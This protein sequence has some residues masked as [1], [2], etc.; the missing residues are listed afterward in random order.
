M[1]YMISKINIKFVLSV[2]FFFALTATAT[3]TFALV[4]DVAISINGDAPATATSTVIVAIEATSGYSG[5]VISNTSDFSSDTELLSFDEENYIT[6]SWNLCLGLPSCANGQHTVY[7]FFFG[8]LVSTTTADASIVLNVPAPI[9]PPPTST[10]PVVSPPTSTPPIIPP[11]PIVPPPSAPPTTPPSIPTPPSSAISGNSAGGSGEETTST[12]ETQEALTK[13][14]SV[15]I[16]PEIKARVEMIA[17]KTVVVAKQAAPPVAVVSTI[18]VVASSAVGV[19][20]MVLSGASFADYVRYFIQ[21]IILLFRFRRKARSWGTV[22][23]AK[24]K[25]PLPFAKVQLLDDKDRVIE[26]RVA[27]QFGRYGFL[28]DLSSSEEASS[29]F[30][31]I[32]IKKGFAFLSGTPAERTGAYYENIYR[33]EQFK[34]KD[35]LLSFN[36]PLDPKLAK[37]KS[38]VKAGGASIHNI[39]ARGSDIAFWIGLVTVPASYFINKSDANLAFLII[40][41]FIDIF[42][43]VGGLRAK[44]CGLV[45]DIKTNMPLAYALVS[46]NKGGHR[47]AFAVTNTRGQYFLLA[48]RGSFVLKFTTPADIQPTR[49]K[50]LPISTKE[51]WIAEVGTV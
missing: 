34:A 45:K 33:G 36:V 32:A 25:E 17:K 23:N 9:I 30:H 51:G 35:K 26:T 7:A 1:E 47:E 19:F 10:P 3:K 28:V 12:N 39:L 14:E 50:E 6:A 38:A 29:M 13:S 37:K 46:L 40:M 21:S 15:L 44:P 11:P 4:G 48:N 24:T 43:V 5:G 2:L 27:D 16:T 18:V 20:S 31:I 8:P 41:A 49:S 22:Y 42:R